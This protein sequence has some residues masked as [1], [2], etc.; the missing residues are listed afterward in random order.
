[1]YD[2]HWKHA[3]EGIGSSLRPGVPQRCD[4][5]AGRARSGVRVLYTSGRLATDGMQSLFVERSA[6]LSKPYTAQQLTEAVAA[7]SV[8]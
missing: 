6:F 8:H 7:R 2:I 5:Q 4:G 1:M 3:A